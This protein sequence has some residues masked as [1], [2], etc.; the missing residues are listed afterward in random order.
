MSEGLSDR[1]EEDKDE[2]LSWGPAVC[3]REK[4]TL[5]ALAEASLAVAARRA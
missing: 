3:L 1:S 4:P 5:G 2:T